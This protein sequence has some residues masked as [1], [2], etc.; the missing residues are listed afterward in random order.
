MITKISD[1]LTCQ[2][3]VLETGVSIPKG[4]ENKK[5]LWKNLLDKIILVK[6]NLNHPPAHVVIERTMQPAKMTN[7]D[8]DQEYAAMYTSDTSDDGPSFDMKDI[9]GETLKWMCEAELTG[10]QAEEVT[11][12][13]SMDPLQWWKINHIKYPTLWRLCKIYHAIPATSASSERAFS[14]RGNIVTQEQCQLATGTVEGMHFL[15][16]NGCFT[17]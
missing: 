8:L 2:G 15:H 10:Y 4:I 5:L 3:V 17:S 16:E 11:L 9:N 13:R 14:I 1:S 6:Q 7:C 12:S